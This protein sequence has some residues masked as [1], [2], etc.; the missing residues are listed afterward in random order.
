MSR[1]GDISISRSSSKRG[2]IAQVLASARASLHD[3][4]RASLQEPTRP[5]TPLMVDQ[6][7][8][9]PSSLNGISFASEGPGQYKAHGAAFSSSTKT[10]VLL[11]ASVDSGLERRSLS[12]PSAPSSASVHQ[13]LLGFL[14]NLLDMVTDNSSS[15]TDGEFCTMLQQLN[16]LRTSLSRTFRTNPN[17]EGRMRKNRAT[18]GLLV[19]VYSIFA[20]SFSPVSF[21]LLRRA[22]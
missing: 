1:N 12:A 21:S 9:F 16:A 3:P 11:S 13:D 10:N 5:V 22:C 2:R 17:K 8:S 4:S 6:W 18:C 15:F 14:V 7:T 19:I 20:C